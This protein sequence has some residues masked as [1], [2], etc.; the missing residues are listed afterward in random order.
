MS[1]LT[2]VFFFLMLV[3]RVKSN[4]GPFFRKNNIW[5]DQRK[6]TWGITIATMKDTLEC[7]DINEEDEKELRR[8]IRNRRIMFFCLIMS[9]I[10]MVY[11]SSTGGALN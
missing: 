2:I 5:F 8:L 11:L 3:Y 7:I 1:N 4:A 10:T 6:N 9:F